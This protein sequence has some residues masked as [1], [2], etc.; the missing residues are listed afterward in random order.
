MPPALVL[1]KKVK[2]TQKDQ[3]QLKGKAEKVKK[4]QISSNSQ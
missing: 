4:A 2:K 1:H 3:N